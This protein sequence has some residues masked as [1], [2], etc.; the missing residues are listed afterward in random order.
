MNGL[1][2]SEAARIF[3]GQAVQ[4]MA[5]HQASVSSGPF[6]HDGSVGYG[7][8]AA[9]EQ[10]RNAA[11]YA[12]EHLLLQRAI[13]RFC[14]RTFGYRHRQPL[15]DNVGEELAIELIHAGYIKNDTLPVAV[16][17][18]LAETL[19][20][21]HEA[22]WV[23]RDAGTPAHVANE[24]V[25]QLASVA[26]EKLIVP[27][28]LTAV[29]AYFAFTH[30]QQ[31]LAADASLSS[32]DAYQA[33]TY[34]AVHRALLKSDL[35][36]VRYDLLRLY[37][38]A[39]SDAISRDPQAYARFNT[40]ID[41][42]FVSKLTDTLTRTISKY[43]APFR[44]LKNLLDD[45]PKA[46]EHLDD[47]NRFLSAFEAQATHDYAV[48]NKRVNRGV[49]KSITF[50]VITKAIIG[51]AI[52]VPYDYW[53]SGAII[54]VPLV[55]NLTFPIAYMAA[56][57]LSMR[58]PG[59]A[60]T[61]ALREY[62]SQA[63]YQDDSSVFLHRSV[64]E[65]RYS[66]AFQVLYAISAITVFGLVAYGLAKL[67]F[68][69]VQ[70]GIFFVFFSTASF[71]G[72]RLLRMVSE[73]EIVT[74]TATFVTIMRDLIYLPFVFVGQWLSDKYAK[75]SIAT[76]ILDTAIELPLKTMLRL[77]RQWTGFLNDT[78]DGI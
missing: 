68:N 59:A 67:D 37:G 20:A 24:W 45:N 52:E 30:Y 29:Y 72:F 34:A 71:L 35:A 17:E 76:L 75:L 6:L 11:E 18:E 2:L 40:Q 48:A 15:A 47:R 41:E 32:Q 44:V 55:I 14:A 26:C 4:A 63:V 23:L 36:N 70:G 31:V 22:Y 56:L 42:L 58:M 57:K 39:D 27:D 60:N 50:L 73:L 19:Q 7:I 53:V 28:E 3:H 8:S 77:V 49:I 33:S 64:G 78:K 13:H 38:L 46:I 5:R 10:L 65:K 21:Y 25:L 1:P 43:G 66:T 74:A 16:V 9:Y 62:I 51:V 69:I 61:T 12:Q 54:V